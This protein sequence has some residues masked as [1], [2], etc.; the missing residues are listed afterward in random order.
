M[1]LQH[2]VEVGLVDGIKKKSRYTINLSIWDYTTTTQ[3]EKL[4]KEWTEKKTKE[5]F[6]FFF[7]IKVYV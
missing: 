1:G 4:V 2:G 6:I 5:K 7:K 3:L